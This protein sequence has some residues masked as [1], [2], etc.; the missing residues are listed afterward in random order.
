MK[1]NSWR[2][3]VRRVAFCATLLAMAPMM[4]AQAAGTKAPGKKQPAGASS[5]LIIENGQVVAEINIHD[6]ELVL[7]HPVPK[8]VQ[9][10]KMSKM[11]KTSKA[12]KVSET[13]MVSRMTR[14]SSM[15]AVQSHEIYDPAQVYDI[16]VQQAALRYSMDPDLLHAVIKV[17]SNYKPLAVS[18]KGAIGL[19]QIMPTTG[20][21]L[22]FANPRRDLLIPM[23]NI[24]AG[25]RYLARMMRRF[26][27]DLSLALAA[28]NAGPSAVS[29]NAALSDYPETRKY[30]RSVLDLYS[31][32]AFK[33]LQLEA[34]RA[35][36]SR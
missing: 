33:A 7:S 12:S 6:G 35:G 8:T 13:S 15:Q 25:T 16:M 30:V 31:R 36:L 1:R 20:V 5:M 11:S 24:D 23:N 32:S 26:E 19:M 17:E 2:D 14:T 18:S 3:A 4:A 9:A 27:G 28:Y 21:E 34:L 22:G 10:S 29:R